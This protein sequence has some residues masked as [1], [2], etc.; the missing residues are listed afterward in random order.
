MAAQDA[1]LQLKVSLDLSFFRQQLATL[2]SAAA[3]YRLPIN[4]KFDRLSIQKEL[5][6]LGANIKKRTYRLNVETN[7]AAEISNAEKLA[8]ALSDL[9]Q[10]SK[11]IGGV[12]KKMAPTGMV[13]AVIDDKTTYKQLQALYK[14]AKEANLPFER[15]AKGAASSTEELKRVLSAGFGE[16]GDD[17]K[18]GI[19]AALKDATSTLAQLGKDMGETLLK[20][21]KKS[22]GIASP[23]R[24]FKKIGENVG[25]GFEL[26]AVGSMDKAFDALERK[27]QERL[28]RLQSILSLAPSRRSA[29]PFVATGGALESGPIA[30]EIDQAYAQIAK[31]Q[32]RRQGRLTAERGS[33]AQIAGRLLPPAR[34]RSLPAARETIFPGGG[35][36]DQVTQGFVQ[37]LRNTRD[38]LARNFSANTYLPRATRA[39][40]TSMDVAT[41]QLSGTKIAGLLPSKEMMEPLRFQRAQQKAAQIDAENIARAQAEQALNQQNLRGMFQGVPRINAPRVGQEETPIGRHIQNKIE[42]AIQNARQTLGLPLGPS[43]TFVPSPFAGAAT[44]PPRQFFQPTMQA[45]LPPAGG[46]GPIAAAQRNIAEMQKNNDRM[47]ASTNRAIATIDRIIEAGRSITGNAPSAPSSQS[48]FAAW[49]QQM[50]AKY[51]GGNVPPV[52]PVPPGGGGGGGGGMSGFGG[53]GRALGGVPNLPGAGTIRELGSE[54]SFATKQVL[55]F[56]QAY[57]LLAFIQDFPGQVSSAVSQLQSFRNTLLSVTGSA[58]A[59]ADANE[60]ILAAVEKYSIPLQSARDGFAKLFA[61]MEPAGFAAGEIQNLFLGVSKAAATYGLSADKVDRVNYAFAQMA[62]KGQVMSEELKG[63]LGDV[64]PGAMGIFAEA[65]GFKGP[66]A[67][68]KFSKALE[69][70]VYK[71]G[72]MRELLRN[73]GDEMNREFGPGAEGAAKTFQGAINR[74]QTATTKLYESFEPAAIGIMNAVMVP[75]VQTLKTATDGINAYFSGQQAATPAAQEFANVLKTLAPTLVGIGENLKYVFQ[76]VAVLIQGFGSFALQIGRLLALPIVRYL[77]G[78]YVQTLLLTT[79]FKALATSGLGAA[80]VAIG[81]FIAQ[82]VVYAQVTLGMRVATQQTTVAMYQ[83]G[84]AVQ[85]VMIKSVIG[86]ALVAIG[87]LI[88]RLVELQNAMASVSGQSKAMGDAAKASAKLGDVAGVKEAIGNMEDRVQTYQRIKGELDKTIKKDAAGSSFYREIPTALAKD[89]MSLGLIVESSMKKV[90]AGYK[91]KIGDLRDAYGLAAKNV[92]EFNGEINKS[93]NLVGKA[94]QQQ[95]KLKE[96]GGLGLEPKDDKA[97][98]GAD[99]LANQQQQLAIDAANRQNALDNARFDHLLK[100][101]ENEFEQWKSLQDAKYDYEL[102]GLNSIEARQLKF[103]KDLQQIE[104]NRIE[105]VRKAAQAVAQAQQEVITTQ[106]TAAAAGGT[107]GLFQGSTGISSGPHFDVRRANGG[108]ISETEARALFSEEVRRTLTMTS[109]Y[110]PRVAPVPGAS[111]FHQ[112]VDLAGPANTPLNL[113]PG[114]S[115]QGVAQEGGLGYTA[116]VSGPTGEMY[117]VGHIQPPGASYTRQRRSEKAGGKEEEAQLQ[118]S[119]RTTEMLTIAQD[120]YTLALAKTDALIKQN[121]TTIFPVAELQ[122]E[123]SLLKMRNQLQMQGMPSE[124]IKYMEESFKAEYEANEAKKTHNVTIDE[125]K[126]KIKDLQDKQAKGTKLTAEEA[127]YLKYAEEQIKKNKDALATLTEQQKAYQIAQLESAIAT[128]KNADALKA[129]EEVSGRINQAVEGV[130]GTYKDM[131]KEIAKGGDSVEALK[132]AQEALADQ[133]LT[134]FFDFAM[135]PVEKFFKDQLGAIFG[136][137]DEEAKRQ[138]QLT[139]MEKQLAELK[140]ARETQQRIDKNVEKVANGGGPGAQQGTSAPGIGGIMAPGGIGDYAAG[141][142]TQL[143][144]ALGSLTESANAYS[145]EL[146]KVDASVWGSAM[147]LGQ[148]GEQMGPNGAAGKTWQQS[149]GSVVSGIGMAAGSIMG[150]MAGINQV[151]EGGT[152]N[153]LGGIGS[154]MTSVGGLLGGFSGMFGGGGAGQF[155]TSSSFNGTAD[156]LG[157]APFAPKIGAVFANGGIARGGFRAF[158]NGGVVNGPTLGLM[159]EGRYNEAIVPLPDGKSIPVQMRSQSSRDLLAGNARQQ[160]SSPVLSMSFQ[161]TKFGDREYVDVAQLQAAMAETRKMAARDG[162]NRGA[163]LALDKL[164]NSPSA[165]RKV[166]MR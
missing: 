100:M 159:G 35:A 14:F 20:E 97:L 126:N 8:K 131:F 6:T 80:L 86:I 48:G 36:L 73:V 7:I 61:S 27:L 156:A 143:P 112:G 111:T 67:I 128:M 105:A 22:L 33:L 76:Q 57:K 166:G 16:I 12:S 52:P 5:N 13:G 99:K 68:Q 21:T 75:F 85:T 102:A 70:G 58:G 81:R 122:L 153:V 115:L 163:S 59:A 137:P 164:Q 32:E 23:S 109:P 38:T 162:A 132:K 89:L 46:T 145:E 19:G 90:G 37:S 24:E 69:D 160:S 77:A 34:D 88:S 117:K 124:Y 95:R 165:R 104:I 30:R 56:G 158:A 26:G 161:T 62:S 50:T 83:F 141:A 71:G 103:Q 43:S 151:K 93:Q 51:G 78:A 110:G 18:A 107:T 106:R 139:A 130:T 140:I 136:V 74:M 142:V 28:K 129:L 55:L 150:I 138:E 121:I 120:G 3:G 47:L 98:K 31:I 39:L 91:V 113:A 40:A 82:G 123:T 157:A 146:G 133:A 116:R 45:A 17:V 148:A 119:L 108:A 118:A 1:E 127:A 72:K 29:F 94:E 114:Y 87:A 9:E 15:L 155:G 63:Q 134:M 60:F 44:V 144:E 135:Q 101:S 65:A 154:I 66:D 152:S 64:L 10:A 149:L 2:G 25:K 125:Y 41:K 79:A 53:F 84:T 49:S 42:Q 92:S 54:F 147:S 4:I 96:Q 11:K